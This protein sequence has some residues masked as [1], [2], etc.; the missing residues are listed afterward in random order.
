[1]KMLWLACDGMNGVAAVSINI[2]LVSDAVHFND[3]STIEAYLE[4][5]AHL[6]RVQI[7][8]NELKI[9]LM[10]AMRGKTADGIPIPAQLIA[11]MN[12]DLQRV[13]NTTSLWPQ[14]RKFDHRIEEST[15]AGL[16]DK[17]YLEDSLRTANSIENASKVVENAL[18]NLVAI[19]MTASPDDI[20]VDKPLHTFGGM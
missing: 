15:E 1:M 10:A 5:Y 11:G 20:D 4:K 19:A 16:G 8:D 14:D 9:V 17:P 13:G 18:K 6:T 12:D 3:A 2:G 7:S